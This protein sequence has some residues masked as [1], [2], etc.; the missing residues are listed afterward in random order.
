MATQ[1]E[2]EEHLRVIRTLM[3]RA[4]IYRAISAPTALVGGGLSIVAAIVQH[5]AFFNSTDESELLRLSQWFGGIWFAVLVLTLSAN[6][7]FLWR[8]SQNRGGHFLSSGMRLALRATLPGLLCGFYFTV[9][10][11]Y[12]SVLR[13]A[14]HGIS[15]LPPL[16][17]LFY[18]LGLLATF[19]FAPRSITRFDWAFLAAGMVSFYL[20]IME[21]WEWLFA[22]HHAGPRGTLD[23]ANVLM[24]ATFG[25]FHLIYAACT[26]P[27][28][29]QH[30]DSG[31][32][33]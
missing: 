27:R 2:A 32:T 9:I 14:A 20:V 16:W 5:L 15:Y 6:T 30:A 29:A 8:G 18:A 13:P 4:T 21:R 24:A 26:W 23:S 11:G 7:Y 22:T 33:P 10:V 31:G 28:G 1:S 19:H 3:E 25:I 17:M 12:E